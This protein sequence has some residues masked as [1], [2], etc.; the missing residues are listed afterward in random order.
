MPR[1]S[2]SA[3]VARDGALEAA[4]ALWPACCAAAEPL[5]PGLDVA[6]VLPEE[7]VV[8]TAF[9]LADGELAARRQ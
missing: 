4:P 2:A 8:L 6:E 3:N 7:P 1:T 9:V 5:A